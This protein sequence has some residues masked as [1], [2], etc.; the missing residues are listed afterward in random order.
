VPET[1]TETFACANGLES[2]Q[3]ALTVGLGSLLLMGDYPIRQL[4]LHSR[5][6]VG[7]FPWELNPGVLGVVLAEG[8]REGEGG[9]A[10][11]LIMPWHS[12]YN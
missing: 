4:I 10:P 11:F 3:N 5:I 9:R 7:W 6:L 12:P 8:I 1:Q 2:R